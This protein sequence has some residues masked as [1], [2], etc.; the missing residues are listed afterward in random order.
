MFLH[1]CEHYT[2]HLKNAHPLVSLGEIN[3]QRISFKTG[4]LNSNE[5]G[6]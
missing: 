3:H 6:N 4:G 2:H 5:V 1:L